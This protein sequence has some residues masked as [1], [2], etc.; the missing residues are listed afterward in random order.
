MRV[1]QKSTQKRGLIRG[2]IGRNPQNKILIN[3]YISILNKKTQNDFVLEF[4]DFWKSNES[5]ISC[6]IFDSKFTIYQNLQ[7]LDEDGVKFITLRRRG[8][9]LAEET[10]KIPEEQWEEV[11]V[12][13]PSRK[14]KKLRIHDSEI[15]L[16]KLISTKFR[17]IIVTEN[18]HN[19][20]SYFIT[21]DRDK[22]ASQI[23]RQ[24]GKRWNVEKGISEQI[25]FFHLNSLSSSIVVK[26][27]F[28]LTMT[29]ASHN[30]Y[31]AMAQGLEGFTKETA[32]SLYNKFFSNGGNFK[33]NN[34]CIKI[35]F[36]KKRHLPLLMEQLQKLT[37]VAIPWLDG[38][39]LEFSIASTS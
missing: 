3:F 25:E 18:G 28:D 34:D 31:R 38:K 15:V 5:K 36:K 24:Y 11:M 12:E 21:N 29:I 17:Q 22:S 14:R 32:V 9:K 23:I 1:R 8:P 13:G 35:E 37:D 20:P 16:N 30:I 4:L 19:K 2:M 27:D 26:V 33:I 6:L 7:K 39:K 10:K